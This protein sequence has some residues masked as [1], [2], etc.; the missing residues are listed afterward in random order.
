MNAKTVKARLSILAAFAAF[1][2]MPIASQA[3]PINFQYTGSI[4]EYVVGATGIYGIV[5][6]GAQGGSIP[7]Y[8]KNPNDNGGLGATI[9]GNLLLVAGQTLEILSGGQGKLGYYP[10]IAAVSPGGGGGSFVVLKD[11]DTLTPLVIAGGGGGAGYGF[12]QDSDNGGPGLAGTSGGNGRGLCSGNGGAAGSGGS[13][14]L[15]NTQPYF[16]QIASAGGGFV[17]DGGTVNF[18]A[19]FGCINAAKGGASF[20]NGGQGGYDQSGRLISGNGGFGGGGAGGSYIVGSG[21]GGGGYSGGG[22]GGLPTN[23]MGQYIGGGA[24]GGG[25]SFFTSLDSFNAVESIAQEGA[26]GGNGYVTIDLVQTVPEP[27]SIA[28]LGLGMLG[29]AASRRKSAK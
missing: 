28:L 21:G 11:G 27:A 15:C 20:V 2:G 25:G 6:A 29:F 9:G 7:N 17:G 23:S 18:C 26:N 4:V 3:G 1:V 8:Y 24:G 14:N 22:G 10:G 12:Y 13:V 5:A 19:F 16:D